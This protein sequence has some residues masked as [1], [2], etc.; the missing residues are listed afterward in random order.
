MMSIAVSVINHNDAAATIECLDSLLTQLVPADRPF[1]LD[2]FIVDN[3]SD[4]RDRRLLENRLPLPGSDNIHVAWL[5]RNL[6]FSAGH[7][8]NIRDIFEGATPDFVWLLNNDCI[9]KADCA[10]HLVECATSSPQTAIWGATLIEPDDATIQCAGGCTYNTWISSFRQLGHGTP[11]EK[12]SELQRGD[13]DYIAGASLFFPAPL[14]KTAFHPAHMEGARRHDSTPL[15]LNEAFFLYFEELDLAQR[16]KPEYDMRWCR[17][18]KIVHSGGKATGAKGRIRSAK[19]E[20]FSSLGALIFTKT[21]FPNRLW[22]MMPAR[23]IAKC[24]QLIF[25]G[26]VRFVRY[27]ARAYV[28]F[29]KKTTPPEL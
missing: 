14:V 3:A 2:I 23:F 12:L 24:I 7:N 20:Y 15:L 1:K 21:Y 5:D 25:T 13:P 27:V 4:T 26:N 16:L 6:G 29:I 8:R 17:Q 10:A 9:V 22:I 11:L 18:A 19:A 28:D